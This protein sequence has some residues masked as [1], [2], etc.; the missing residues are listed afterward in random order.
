[1]CVGRKDFGPTSVL[2]PPC[3]IVLNGAMLPAW[4]HPSGERV[5]ASCGIPVCGLLLS[6]VGS[7][8]G[9]RLSSRL[10]I[11]FLNWI[12]SLRRCFTWDDSSGRGWPFTIRKNKT[13]MND[14]FST[15]CATRYR[16][17]N[18]VSYKTRLQYCSIYQTNTAFYGQCVLK[19]WQLLHTPTHPLTQRCSFVSSHM[20]GTQVC[21]WGWKVV[22]SCTV[23]SATSMA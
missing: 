4:R 22:E 1:M 6:S 19:M 8:G 10:L 17:M 12:S 13:Q 16:S 9:S 20:F 7:A 23:Q 14:S 5:Q 15:R 3:H 21:M 18:S 11:L 2:M